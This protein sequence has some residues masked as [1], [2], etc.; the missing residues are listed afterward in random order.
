MSRIRLFSKKNASITAGLALV[1]A[2]LVFPAYAETPKEDLL[3]KL[4]IEE[5][6]GE[7][8]KISLPFSIF[9]TSI[10]IFAKETLDAVKKEIGLDL[11]AF[12]EELRKMEGED[13]VKIEGDENISLRLEKATDETRK[14]L[15]FLRIQVDEGKNGNKIKVCLP[16]GI[17]KAASQIAATVIKQAELDK[18]I[19]AQLPKIIEELKKNLEIK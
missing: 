10:D 11:T 15:E 14:D 13:I 9:Y 3:F 16:I 19:Q 2:A 7:S 12:L 4:N 8:V 18:H 17:V 5:K 6:D 1:F